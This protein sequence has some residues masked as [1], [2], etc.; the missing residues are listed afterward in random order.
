MSETTVASE[1]NRREPTSGELAIAVLFERVSRLPKEDQ[2]DFFELFKIIVTTGDPEEYRAAK[3]AIEEVIEDA[4]CQLSDEAFPTSSK[5]AHLKWKEFISSKIRTARKT[6]KLTQ[7]KL[8]ELADIEQATLSRIESRKTS[9]SSHTVAKI[10]RALGI[11]PG[12][13]DPSLD[14]E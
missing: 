11:K 4:P 14:G 8:A 13:L 6:R 12:E 5:E 7:K 10:A 2:N 1:P 9:P 3:E